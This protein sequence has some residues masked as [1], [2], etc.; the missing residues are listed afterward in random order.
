[1][2]KAMPECK[3]NSCDTIQ[4]E[5]EKQEPKQIW[6]REIL[7]HHREIIS[8]IQKSFLRILIAERPSA[9]VI[10]S[11]FSRVHDFLSRIFQSPAQIYFFLMGKKTFI[12]TALFLEIFTPDKE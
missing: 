2:R 7:Q 12:E 10:H 6:K 8:K 5:P 1:M 9:N 3:L 4:T 11:R